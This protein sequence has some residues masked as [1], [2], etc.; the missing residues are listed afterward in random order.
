M[1][2]FNLYRLANLEAPQMRVPMKRAALFLG[3]IKGPNV[4][5]WVKLRTNETLARFN[6]GTD[7]NDEVYWDEIGQQFIDSFWD[8]ASRERAEEKLRHLSWI[9]GDVDSFVA[10][11]RNLAD[12]AEY[13]L[14]DRPTISLFASKLPFKMMEHIFRVVKPRNF[15]GWVDAA[16]D[17]HQSNTAIQGLRGEDTPRK[18]INK[19]TAKQWAHLLGVKLPASMDPDAM[20]TR[21]DRSRSFN[22]NKFRGSK[23]RTTITKEDPETQ[24]KEGRCYSCNKQ[25]HIARNCPAKA[26]PDKGKVKARSAATEA[27]SSDEEPPSFETEGG[28]K[29]I[30]RRGRALNEERKLD[31]V[32]MIAEDEN[33]EG[34]D[35]DF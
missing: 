26:S 30:I 27:E 8:T 15:N 35:Q 23:G 33:M 31:I 25:G 29:T 19:K 32:R 16:R 6:A 17:Y 20:D 2:Q 5:D 34:D 9:P 3:F 4:D 28:I 14:N 21:A 10:Q 13:Q 12:Q 22:R 18:T 1:N 11:F 24:R 7:P